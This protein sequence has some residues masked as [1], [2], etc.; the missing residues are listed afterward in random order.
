[1]TAGFKGGGGLKGAC[2]SGLCTCN[3]REMRFEVVGDGG[4]F[5]LGLGTVSLEY[6]RW[7]PKCL[8]S[9][10]YYIKIPNISSD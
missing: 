8:V 9:L 7:C 6:S 1:M 4:V 10:K 3:E 2:R 5:G